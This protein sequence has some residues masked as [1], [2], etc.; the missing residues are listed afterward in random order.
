M[1]RERE[2][3]RERGEKRKHLSPCCRWWV[4]CGESEVPAKATQG[5]VGRKPAEGTAP[6][7]EHEETGLADCG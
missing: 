7:Q 5:S 1:R 4:C 3:E 2:R 6:H